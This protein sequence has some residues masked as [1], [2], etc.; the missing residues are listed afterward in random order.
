MKVIPNFHSERKFQTD[1]LY[2]FLSL[3]NQKSKS[4]WMEIMWFIISFYLKNKDAVNRKSFLKVGFG[5]IM[6]VLILSEV[7]RYLSTLVLF[8]VPGYFVITLI[9]LVTVIYYLIK[10]N[11]VFRFN[12][13][14]D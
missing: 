7:R 1:E 10:I 13:I 5:T 11:K 3:E 2:Q 8:S 9:A 6:L 12:R 14:L 4:P